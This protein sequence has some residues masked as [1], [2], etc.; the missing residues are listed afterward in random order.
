MT[1]E[2]RDPF[3]DEPGR[4]K[5]HYLLRNG[6]IVFLGLTELD[7]IDDVA[8]AL[9][10]MPESDL[11]CV[12]LERLYTWHASKGSPP[13]LPPNEWLGLGGHDS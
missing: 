8:K 9:D 11:K 2:P 5:W 4:T 13:N 3:L 6:E 1:D 10:G 7:T 12:V